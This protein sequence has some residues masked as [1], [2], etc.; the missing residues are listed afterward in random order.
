MKFTAAVAVVVTFI[1]FGVVAKPAPQLSSRVPQLFKRTDCVDVWCY[2]DRTG[3]SNPCEC[4]GS[5][6]LEAGKS[7]VYNC[8]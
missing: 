6:C 1:A 8:T 2:D 3:E 7:R 4:T 5:I